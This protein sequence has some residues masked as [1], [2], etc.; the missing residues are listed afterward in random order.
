MTTVLRPTRSKTPVRAR[1]MIRVCGA[2]Q[3]VGFRPFVHRQAAGLGLAGWVANTSEGVIIEAEG[4]PGRLK[5]LLDLI[6][7]SPPPH[8]AI[9][10]M[11]VSE[12]RPLGETTF[13][14]RP[15]T[16]AGARTAQ[17][18][19]D[20]ATCDA[21]LAELLDPSDRRYLYPFINCTQCGP[22][23]SIIEDFPYDRARTSMRGFGMC[24]A[25]QAEYEDP[26]SR[27]FH[28]EPNACPDCGPR[29]A[30]WDRTGGVLAQDHEALA[31]AAAAIGQGQIAAVKGIGGFHLL[32]DA[33]SD[34]AVQRLRALK[35]RPDKP[36]AVMFP[37]FDDLLESCQASPEERSLLTAPERPIVLLRRSGEA[38]ADAVAP[39]NSLL[40]AILPYSPLHHLLLNAL[41][42]PVVATSGNLSEEPIAIDEHDALERLEG[43]AD[44]FLVHDRP[45][46]RPAE[47]SVMRV[48]CA[49]P[50]MLRRARGYAPV[51]IVVEGMSAG[52]LAVGGHLKTTVALSRDDGVVLW[53]HIGDLETVEGRAAHTRAAEDIVRLHAVRPNLIAHDLH[54][55]YAS[56]QAMQDF[57]APVLPVQHHLAHVVACMADNGVAPPVL[58]VAWDGAGYGPDDTLWGG[59][60]LRVTRDG[61][62]R[63]AHL[64]PFHLPGG[65]AAVR[66]PRRTALGLLYAAFGDDALAMDDLAP[67]AAFTVAERRTLGA[68]L[69]GGVNAPVCSSVG[70]LFDAVAALAGLRQRTSFEGQAASELETAAGDRVGDRGYDFP[71]GGSIGDDGGLILDWGPAL[72]ALLADLRTGAAPGE[73][74]LALHNGLA[75]AIVDVASRVGERRVALTGGCFQNA[76]LTKAT[77]EALHEAGFEPLWHR[78]VPPND[79]GLALGQA[80]WAAW[81]EGRGEQPCV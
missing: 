20:L 33:R 65:A 68:M 5:S 79:G 46:V 23:F 28:A 42:F 73:I 12:T 43:I 45:I 69:A 2:V 48:V 11:E 71:I 54:P 17:V 3:G 55:D 25:C 80:V 1:L 67:V 18:M 36:F 22:R 13:V 70:R 62:R 35:R 76:R 4:E 81:A 64:R 37:T 34:T 47:D 59:E 26:T 6:V 66:E 10:T 7:R 58:G 40:G 74:S 57:A 39:G 72:A 77:A 29:L 41:G 9:T 75:A 63:V 51:P 21:C 14:I 49:R 30:L 32:V 19:P 8:A 24:A 50:L 52:V 53:P 56:S 38:V 61:W 78:R 27:R 44:L 31:L 15:S 60:F 16:L